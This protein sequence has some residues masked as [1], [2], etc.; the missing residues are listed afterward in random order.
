MP[1][2]FNTIDDE[3]YMSNY[4]VKISVRNLIEY[5][6][7]AGS[8]ESVALSSTRAVDGTRDI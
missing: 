8:I 7:R 5:I 2:F 6:L 3:A 4:V 1:T